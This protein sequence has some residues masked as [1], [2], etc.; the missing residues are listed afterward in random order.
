MAPPGP[1]CATDRAGACGRAGS[2]LD[3]LGASASSRSATTSRMAPS[4]KWITRSA[5]AA[6]LAAW[7]T[8]RTVE[9]SRSFTSASTFSTARPVVLSSAPVGSSQNSTS[10]CLAT[11]RAMATRCCSP[12]ESCAGKV[13]DPFLQPDQCQR[14][15]RVH[16]I[17]GD[18]GHQFDIL[19]RGQAGHQVVELKHEADVIA[20]VAGQFAC[21]SCP[22]ATGRENARF[23]PSRGPARR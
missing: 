11:A 12:P 14:L 19:A 10:G 4:A 8:I 17:V 23:R 13:I 5:I 16:R 15:V 6:V 2:P 7:V 18:L 1:S 3:L 21:R 9:P 22:S 20:P